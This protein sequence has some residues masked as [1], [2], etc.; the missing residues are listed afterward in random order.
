VA[1][2]TL[3]PSHVRRAAEVTHHRARD[4]PPAA[5]DGM[6]HT[7][8]PDLVREPCRALQ[9]DAAEPAL[10]R[11]VLAAARSDVQALDQSLPRAED[12]LQLFGETEAIR[13]LPRDR[14]RLLVGNSHLGVQD[15][16]P[17]H[18]HLLRLVVVTGPLPGLARHLLEDG[19]TTPG[20]EASRELLLAA[21][22]RMYH[23]QRSCLNIFRP[24]A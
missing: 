19:A 23:C 5:A 16:I 13:D 17:R 11:A 7:V 8:G 20:V 15:A 3:A 14:H 2:P 1:G 9:R 10:T 22:E 4:L 24:T 12:R 21:D 6:H 18:L